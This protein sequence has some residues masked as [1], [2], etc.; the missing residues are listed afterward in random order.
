MDWGVNRLQPAKIGEDSARQFPLQLPDRLK[1][2]LL[3]NSR[4]SRPTTG[5]GLPGLWHR[6]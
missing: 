3:G 2:F 4:K 5:C 6:I 1:E